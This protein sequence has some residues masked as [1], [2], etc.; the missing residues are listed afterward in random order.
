MSALES[1]QMPAAEFSADGV[2]LIHVSELTN[3]VTEHLKDFCLL[4]DRERAR[5]YRI[6]LEVCC[7]KLAELL[8]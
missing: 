8:P 5:N 3:L 4:D 2:D 7:K 1:N 6:Q